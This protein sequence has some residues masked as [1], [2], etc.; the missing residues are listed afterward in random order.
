MKF[1]NTHFSMVHEQFAWI[2]RR[3]GGRDD[4]FPGALDSLSGPVRIILTIF[5]TSSSELTLEFRNFPTTR[6]WTYEKNFLCGTKTP[7]WVTTSGKG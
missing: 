5:Q 7:L 1:S 4:A 6:G 2:D 3:G